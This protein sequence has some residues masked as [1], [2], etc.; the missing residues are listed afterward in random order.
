MKSLPS[1]ALGT[2]SWGTGVIGGEQVSGNN[3]TP[4][5][6]KNTLPIIG[7]TKVAQ[8]ED[9]ANASKITLSSDEVERIEILAAK[10]GVDTRGS[11][12]KPMA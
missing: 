7:V 12:E 8:V 3:L 10:T 6:A 4:E 9:A 1:I 5:V 2:W 11:W